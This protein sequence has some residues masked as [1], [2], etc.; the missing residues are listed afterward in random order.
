MSSLEND[1]QNAFRIGNM[2]VIHNLLENGGIVNVSS[3]SRYPPMIS[4]SRHNHLDLVERL[5]VEGENVNCT[6]KS[7]ETPLH[8]ACEF[9]NTDIVTFAPFSARTLI[10]SAQPL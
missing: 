8:L 1:L 5:L 10:T 3:E 6:I 9:V 7:G 2:D 4:A